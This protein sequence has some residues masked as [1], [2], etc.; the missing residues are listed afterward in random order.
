M[1]AALYDFP[2]SRQIIDARVAVAKPSGRTCAEM[3]GHIVMLQLS[4]EHRDEVLAQDFL[5]DHAGDHALMS[6]LDMKPQLGIPVTVPPETPAT[7]FA[8]HAHRWPALIFGGAVGAV[9][10]LAWAGWV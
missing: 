10:I 6:Y 8:R 7:V 1:T 2:I 3:A 4:G 5:R 9:V